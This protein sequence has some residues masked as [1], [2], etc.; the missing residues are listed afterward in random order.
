[1]LKHHMCSKEKRKL[2][3]RDWFQYVVWFVRVRKIKQSCQTSSTVS[4]KLE[5]DD[6]QLHICELEEKVLS[7]SATYLKVSV[8]NVLDSF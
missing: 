6:F 5:V 7:L 1:M 8:K 3:V 2:I 4:L